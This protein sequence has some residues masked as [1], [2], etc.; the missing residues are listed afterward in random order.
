MSTNISEEHSMSVFR[1]E[2][3]SSLQVSEK[4]VSIHKSDNHALEFHRSLIF[5][6][7]NLVALGF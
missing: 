7:V 6:L 2:V 1:V 4:S 5:N 3:A